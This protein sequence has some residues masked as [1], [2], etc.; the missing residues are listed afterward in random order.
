[1]KAKWG[2]KS[3]LAGLAFPRLFSRAAVLEAARTVLSTQHSD[4]EVNNSRDPTIGC[5]NLA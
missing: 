2:W 1:M 3:D 5:A 4:G